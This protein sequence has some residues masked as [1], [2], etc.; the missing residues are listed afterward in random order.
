MPTV[1]VATGNP[2]KLSEMQ[3]HLK[4]LNWNLKLKPEHLEIDETGTTFLENARIKAS[5]VA[6]A[7]GKWSIADD[8]G[9]EVDALEGA[10]GIYSARYADTDKAR[11]NRL[12]EELHNRSDR[13]AQFTCAIALARPDGTIAIETQG[14]CRGKILKTPRGNGGFG[15]DPI[16]YVEELD[17]SF[18]EMSPEQKE[19]TSHRGLA[20]QQLMPLLNQL[21]IND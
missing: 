19:A 12:L 21:E 1:V 16:F 8:S 10:P 5:G 9:L 7:T 15:Y 17:K 14:I 6:Q 13:G 20:F 4:S 2:G 11:I 3:S 18:A